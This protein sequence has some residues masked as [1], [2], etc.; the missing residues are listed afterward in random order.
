MKD[1]WH[2][3]IQFVSKHK[4][5]SLAYFLLLIYF[6]GESLISPVLEKEV[7][8]LA[9]AGDPSGLM[10]VA[11][12]YVGLLVITALLDTL[13]SY[14]EEYAKGSLSNEMHRRTVGD[15]LRMH[16]SRIRAQKFGQIVRLVNQ[17]TQSIERIGT[18]TIPHMIRNAI[19]AVAMMVYLF[20][21]NIP[22]TCV[23]L[24]GIIA[25]FAG[26]RLLIPLIRQRQAALIAQEEKLNDLVDEC[27]AGAE[28]IRAMNAEPFFLKRAQHF[29]INCSIQD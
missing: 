13:M 10:S 21:I 22:L 28:S 19:M 6:L 5:L 27:F 18:T 11:I 29:W 12:C 7:I 20:F 15:L 4:W 2:L 26:N 1:A 8:D 14:I 25:V 23:L 3:M 17:D 16:F 9:V 24:V